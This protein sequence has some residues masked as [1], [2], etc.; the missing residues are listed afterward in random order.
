MVWEDASFASVPKNTPAPGNYSEWKA[1]NQVFTDMAATRGAIALLACW[2]P[3][4][5]ASRVDPI[6]VL[7]EE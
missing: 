3:A 7:R 6:V 5:R 2:I 4:R 1:Q